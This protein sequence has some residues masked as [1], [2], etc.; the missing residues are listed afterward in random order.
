MQKAQSARC[1]RARDGVTCAARGHHAAHW[2][3]IRCAACGSA[4]GWWQGQQLVLPDAAPSHLL[5]LP[6]IISVQ[7]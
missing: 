5:H 4:A 7:R 6:V 1:E 3:L 2:L